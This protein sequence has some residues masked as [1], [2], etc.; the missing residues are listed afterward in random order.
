MAPSVSEHTPREVGTPLPVDPQVRPETY[1]YDYII[2][3]GGTAGCVVASRLSED[4][5]V[6]VLVIEQGPVDDSWLS[7]VPLASGN[8]YEGEH[9]MALRWWS[10]PLRHANNRFLEIFQGKALGGASRVSGMLYTRGTPGDYN[11]WK[12]L[13]NEGW[14]YD[15]LLPYFVK[16]E[17][18][19]SHPASAYRG[20]E[21]VWQNRNFAHSPY[22]VTDYADRACQKLGF[23]QVPDPNA[24]NVPAAH[25]AVLDSMQD[26]KY[27]R[28]STFLAFLPPHVAQERKERLKICPNSV[29]C[30]VEL[31][32]SGGDVRAT[33]VHFE[34]ANPRKADAQYVAKARREVI[35]CAGAMGSPQILMLSGLGPKA[36]LEDKG[37]DVVLDLPAVGSHLSDHMGVPV[38]VE[39][40]IKDSLHQLEVSPL[41]AVKE[42]LKYATTGRSVLARPFQ[43]LSAFFP[44]RLVDPA[45]HAVSPG[46]DGAA[47]L[48]AR[49]PAN[50][51]DIEMM[52]L[53]NNCAD[54]DTPKGVGVFT[55]A[56]AL[57]RPRSEGAVRLATANPRV[58]P[59]VDL[60]Y[61]S[62]PADYAPLRS[63]IRLALRGGA[64]ASNDEALDAWIR[65]HLR[66]FCHFTSTC[67][68]GAEERESVVDAQLRVHGVKGLR[69]ADTS[70]FPEIIGAHTMAP[71]VAV[72]EKCA[73]MVKAAWA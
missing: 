11:R 23:P 25:I 21:G 49:V 27:R 55:L 36:H 50:R 38:A 16:S 22:K 26:E 72:A 19:H 67:R 5:K 64:S 43:N 37:V 60:G 47:D 44:S 41:T 7:R 31:A 48:D 1:T 57:V 24:P 29:V 58:R 56:V 10:E 15:D 51:P 3:G 63:G 30:R 39:V 59:A 17:K 20:R 65:A 69:I 73:D 54:V 45:S 61:L 6:S 40:P 8:I 2:V 52:L 46:P 14:G 18:T 71:A 62:D 70:V 34:T 12:E 9:P 28:N 33:G 68:M 53:T 42:V 4:Q 35:V 66:T 32:K 13:G